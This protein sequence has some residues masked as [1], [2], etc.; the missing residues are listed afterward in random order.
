MSQSES[1]GEL[2]VSNSVISDYESGRRGTPVLVT[3]S[4]IIEVLLD[5]NEKRGGSHIRQ[6]ALLSSA[7]FDNSI[8]HGLR[9]FSVNVPIERCYEA[10]DASELVSGRRDAI[11]SYTVIDSIETIRHLSGDG[12]YNLYGQSTNRAL[13][14]TNNSQGKGHS[15]PSAS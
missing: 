9:E 14:F 11:V 4:R 12:F 2:G 5:I 1:A 7:G 13:V 15:S 6:H 10:I 8:V 3:V